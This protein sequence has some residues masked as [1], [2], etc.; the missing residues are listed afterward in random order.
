MRIGNSESGIDID[1]GASGNTIGGTTANARNVISANTVSGIDISDA[2]TNG[3]VVLGNYIGTDAGGTLDRGNAGD[4]VHVFGGA[5]GTVI[6][7]S[8]AGAGNLISGN[9]AA[10]VRLESSGTFVQ[11]NR[12][13]TNAA[14]TGA[15]RNELSGVVVTGSA[16]TIGGTVAGAGNL[17]SGNFENGLLFSGAGATSN[18]VLGNTMGLN[19]TGNGLLANGLSGVMLLNGAGGN[20]IGGTAA[21]ARNVLSGNDQDGITG[22]ASNG[23]LIQGNYIG[24]DAGGTL[25][26]GNVEDGIYFEDSSNN[27]VGGTSPGAGNVL[28]GNGW[29]G[30]T[31]WGTGSGNIAQGNIIG[32]NAAAPRRSAT[33]RLASWSEPRPRHGGRDRAGSRQPDCVQRLVRGDDHARHRALG[34]R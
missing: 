31:F 30:V 23:N 4:G 27:V 10:G 16:N 26:R 14:G 33:R 9:N 12:V 25:D 32:T 17:L 18:V 11:G 2:G 5:T 3:N 15:V 21:G 19:A 6:G 1:N 7:G 22:F 20:T 13:G 29:T 8:A 28:S 24:T 34:A